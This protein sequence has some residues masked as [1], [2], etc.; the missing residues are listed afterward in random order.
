MSSAPRPR[1]QHE[2]A[3]DPVRP[4][5]VP[6]GDGPAGPIYSMSGK[7]DQNPAGIAFFALL[8]EDLRT[9][10][11]LFAQGFWAIAVNRLGNRRMA[12]R[13]R[14][15]RA[16]LTVLYDFLYRVVHW[17]AR[18]ELPYI[19]KVG[20]RV[21]IWHHGGCVLGACAIGDDVQI[22]HN[23]TLGKAKH[24]DPIHRLPILEERVIVGA[25]AVILGPVRIGHDSVIAANAV[26]TQ[27]VPP[28]S[29][30]AGIPGRVIKTLEGGQR[31]TDVRTKV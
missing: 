12:V 22:R 31:Q 19:V 15:L 18:I 11:S 10:Q 13:N 29:V 3:P 21:R 26:V 4:G 25:G 24:E 20:R 9:H 30:V 28:C 14:L 6:K 23:V 17:T 8:R 7:A 27:D 1:P 5:P 2:Y 16:P